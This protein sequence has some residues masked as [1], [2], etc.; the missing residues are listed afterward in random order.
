MTPHD[1]K[2]APSGYMSP[3][4]QLDEYTIGYID[5]SFVAGEYICS[6]CG[7]DARVHKSYGTGYIYVSDN[8][9]SD[10]D[11]VLIHKVIKS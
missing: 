4:Y 1:W 9:G 2:P 10:C 5:F 8:W 11:I 6:R 7:S 3:D